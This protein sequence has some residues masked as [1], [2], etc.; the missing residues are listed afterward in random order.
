MKEF[1]KNNINYLIGFLVL[2]IG[3]FLKLNNNTTLLEGDF[4]YFL[5]YVLLPYIIW[6]FICL[7]SAI[8]L[9]ESIKRK[10]LQNLIKFVNQPINY[11]IVLAIIITSISIFIDKY[12]TVILFSGLIVVIIFLKMIF[13]KN[14][15]YIGPISFYLL[16]VIGGIIPHV[17]IPLAGLVLIWIIALLCIIQLLFLII[18][19]ITLKIRKT[20]KNNDFIFLANFLLLY[21]PY[22]C[23]M[24]IIYFE[25]DKIILGLFFMLISFYATYTMYDVWKKY[26]FRSRELGI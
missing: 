19:V 13:T 3:L 7:G 15:H 21:L 12:D 16:L 4:F 8:I 17:T 26:V 9:F 25:Y 20:I 22:A 23:L 14:Y 24:L 5:K 6:I 18:R 2:F 11:F 10:Q 1:S